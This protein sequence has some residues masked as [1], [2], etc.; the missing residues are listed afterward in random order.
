MLRADQR[1]DHAE[2]IIERA[3][4]LGVGRDGRRFQELADSAR[5]IGKP[6]AFSATAARTLSHSLAKRQNG[7]RG[8]FRRCLR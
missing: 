8:G 7:V 4:R 5:A 6:V 2:K 1:V 3:L